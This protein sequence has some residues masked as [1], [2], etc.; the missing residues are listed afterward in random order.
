M[1][2]SAIISLDGL[3]QFIRPRCAGIDMAIKTKVCEKDKLL[4]GES[5]YSKESD[6]K[7]MDYDFLNDEII[8]RDRYINPMIIIPQEGLKFSIINLLSHCLGRLVNDYMERYCKSF[9]TDSNTT[10]MI[11]LKNE[12]NE[13][14][15]IEKSMYANFSNCW[16]GS[17][18]QISS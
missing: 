18:E 12:S 1:T 10:C 13:S 5:E 2:D 11:T 14:S 4:D 3:Y 8:E 16:K 17:V 15:C 7:V 9:H 6:V